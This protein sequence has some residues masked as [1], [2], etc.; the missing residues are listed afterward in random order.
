MSLLHTPHELANT[1]PHCGYES[2]ATTGVSCKQRPDPGCVNVC[3]ECLEVSLFDEQLKLRR[4]TEEEERNVMRCAQSWNV[5]EA[6]RKAI[7]TAKRRHE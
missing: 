6:I 1:C 5:I 4:M 3:I 2:D 7:I